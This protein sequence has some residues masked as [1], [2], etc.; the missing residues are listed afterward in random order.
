MPVLP[1]TG[2][3]PVEPGYEHVGY[4][5][6][7]LYHYLYIACLANGSTRGAMFVTHVTS[8]RGQ[9][10][11]ERAGFLPARQTVRQIYL[12][13]RPLGAPAN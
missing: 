7:P 8:D 2:L 3:V 9:R 4:G 10:Q 11:V 12:T 13:R 6:Y 1:D 5:E